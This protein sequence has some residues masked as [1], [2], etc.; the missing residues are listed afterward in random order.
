MDGAWKIVP[1]EEIGRDKN[2]WA[3]HPCFKDLKMQRKADIP[4]SEM[5]PG[6]VWP[7]CVTGLC[8]YHAKFIANGGV[9]PILDKMKEKAE[10]WGQHGPYLGHSNRVGVH[11]ANMILMRWEE[12]KDSSRSGYHRGRIYKTRQSWAGESI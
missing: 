7:G 4:L 3:C 1:F 12:E 8:A 9:N 11:I 2:T 10:T 5:Y 6:C